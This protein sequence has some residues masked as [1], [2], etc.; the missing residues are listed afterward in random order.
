MPLSD[1]FVTEIFVY[2]LTFVIYYVKALNH[3]SE[4]AL[5]AGATYDAISF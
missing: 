2:L 3:S 4:Q 1:L 5:A